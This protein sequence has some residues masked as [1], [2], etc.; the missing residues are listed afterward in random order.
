MKKSVFTAMLLL[1]GAAWV[2]F[3]AE[4]AL[5]FSENFNDGTVDPAITSSTTTLAVDTSPSPVSQMFLGRNDGPNNADPTN[6]GLGNDT[7][8]LLVNSASHNQSTLNFSLYLIST[9]DGDETFQLSDATLGSLF[10][11]SCENLTAG[12]A[13]CTIS[14]VNPAVSALTL[15]KTGE[16]SLG[17]TDSNPGAVDDSSFGLSA[18]FNYPSAVTQTLLTFGYGNFQVVGSN[19]LT[20]E[21][22]G[23]DNI[24]L[25]TN[26]VNGLPPTGA[27]EPGSLALLSIAL[28]G[29][30]ITRRRTRGS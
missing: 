22:W 23:L 25:A 17:F 8:Q 13:S 1:L 27:P 6:R 28:G 21:S 18:T 11:L 29:L 9:L 4:A 30:W 19:G 5:I 14:N 12:G 15:T 3:T 20:D 7:V 26:A 2:P 16:N 10:T 24:A